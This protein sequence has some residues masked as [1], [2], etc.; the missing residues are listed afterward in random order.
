MFMNDIGVATFETDATPTG[1]GET[2][3]IADHIVAKEYSNI[4]FGHQ[5][6]LIKGVIHV[7]G[8]AGDTTTVIFDLKFAS[9]EFA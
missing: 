6:L 1:I 4:G 3:M 2:T 7:F 8:Q 9:E 5:E